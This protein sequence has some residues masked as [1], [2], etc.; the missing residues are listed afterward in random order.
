MLSS[1][2][3]D[4]LVDT[5]AAMAGLDG[6][7]AWHVANVGD[8]DAAEG[9]VEATVERFGSLDILVNNAAT[10]PYFGPL[11]EIDIGRAEKTCAGQP[12]G[13]PGVDAVRVACLV[14]RGG[15]SVI[16]LSSIGAMSVERASV[17]TTSPRPPSCT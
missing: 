9:C 1:R 2:K 16:N 15:G 3:A 14:G 10:N 11:M 17:G 7:V 5:A 6:D 8:P 4:A 13:H 12:G